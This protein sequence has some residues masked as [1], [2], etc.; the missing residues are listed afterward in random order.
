MAKRRRVIGGKW[1]V[2]PRS[3]FKSVRLVA[4][5]AWD[6]WLRSLLAL[7]ARDFT[8]ARRLQIVGV[9]AVVWLAGLGE[10]LRL[11]AGFTPRR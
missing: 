3:I 9:I 6:A 7:R 8:L 1:A 11:T 2:A 4:V 10:V 5:L